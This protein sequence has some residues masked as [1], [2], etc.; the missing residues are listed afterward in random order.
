M[1]LLAVMDALALKFIRLFCE[2]SWLEAPVSE[3]SDREA[4]RDRAFA[5]ACAS[6]SFRG[7]F[8]DAEQLLGLA[9]EFLEYIQGDDS[10]QIPRPD[11]TTG[12]KVPRP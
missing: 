4:R 3:I 12:G 11:K 1:R 2:P 10:A 8:K 5:I 6:V 9:D 7:A